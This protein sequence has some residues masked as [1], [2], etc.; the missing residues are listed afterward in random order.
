MLLAKGADANAKAA[1]SGTAL[2]VASHNGHSD[3]VGVLLAKGAHVNA[4][5]NDGF[6]A[7]IVASQFGH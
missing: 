3:I 6:T 1:N 7:L 5:S 4:K 2:I